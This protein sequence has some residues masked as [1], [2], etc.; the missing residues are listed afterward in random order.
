[1]VCC[2][3]GTTERQAEFYNNIIVPEISKPEI[4]EL[5]K[6]GA[7]MLTNSEVQVFTLHSS[8]QQDGRKSFQEF[9]C[10]E[11]CW[12]EIK[13]LKMG[14]ENSRHPMR[15][16]EKIFDGFSFFLKLWKRTQDT[17]CGGPSCSNRD[18]PPLP[19]LSVKLKR[20]NFF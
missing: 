17:L 2:I 11:K 9:K 3:K 18:P 15:R 5:V 8:P 19:G 1:M 6:R 7:Y 10:S 13:E 12:S 4:L 16:I 20:C 14:E